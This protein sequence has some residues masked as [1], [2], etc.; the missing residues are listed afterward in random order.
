[1][2]LE[3]ASLTFSNAAVSGDPLYFPNFPN[4]MLNINVLD[5]GARPIIQNDIL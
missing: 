1:S 5:W 4:R 2:T 3:T